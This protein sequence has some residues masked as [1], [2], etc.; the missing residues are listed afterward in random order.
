MLVKSNY[1]MSELIKIGKNVISKDSK[2]YFIADIGANWDGSLIRA[3][4]LIKL[5]A[6]A[7]ANAAKFQNFNAETIVSDLGFIKLSKNIKTHQSKWR[8]SVFETYK[9]AS[10]PLEW[11][12][13][14]YKECKKNNIDYFT[15]PYDINQLIFLDKYCSAWKIGSGDITWHEMIEKLSIYKKPIMIASGASN[16]DEVK[17]AVKIILR[18][19]KKLILMQC[20]TNYTGSENNIEYVNLNVLKKYSKLFPKV[21][22]GL[23][24]HTSGHISVLGAVAMGARVIEKHFTDDNKRDGPDHSF[25]MNPD[26]WT[27]MVSKT[28]E[29]EKALGDGV[30]R[31]EKNELKSLRVQR[32]SIRA[33]IDL[34]KDQKLTK[35]DLVMLRPISQNGLDPYKINNILGMKLKK[36]IKK[37]EEITKKGLK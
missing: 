1:K 36:N 4:K 37:G 28:R 17:K 16:L 19:N 9:K 34:K 6:A 5:C 2:T 13:E 24:D 11:T 31:V 18:N 20:N 26:T 23:S 35:K 15:S 12:A 3:K 10:I 8:T 30:K 32:R 21:V 29:L 27:I 7:G 22:L 14:L 25:A 33:N